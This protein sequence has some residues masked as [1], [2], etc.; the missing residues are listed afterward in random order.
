MVKYSE[1]VHFVTLS[2]VERKWEQFLGNSISLSV[3]FNFPKFL[4][5][6]WYA[7]ATT[8][9]DVEISIAVSARQQRYDDDISR[10]LEKNPIKK[11]HF[12]A[13]NRLKW[14]L[15]VFH[16]HLLSNYIFFA[17]ATKR[18]LYFNTSDWPDLKKFDIKSLIWNH[19]PSLMTIGGVEITFM[20]QISTTI[21]NWA[22]AN[23]K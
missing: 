1:I 23:D 22:L 2:P 13:P 5:F 21:D 11:L 4:Y 20:N 17:L 3:E 19:L 8:L 16:S 7:T 12:I 14:E 18:R 15:H 6:F 10:I 9:G